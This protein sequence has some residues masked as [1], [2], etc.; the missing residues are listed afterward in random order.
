MAQA[1]RQA[2]AGLPPVRKNHAAWA[3][4]VAY[5]IFRKPIRMLARNIVLRHFGPQRGWR[6]RLRERTGGE[7]NDSHDSDR[8]AAHRLVL[9]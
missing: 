8:E 3:G 6:G 4:L 2:D 7:R 5:S 9:L 1:L